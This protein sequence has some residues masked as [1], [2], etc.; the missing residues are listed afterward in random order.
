MSEQAS[1]VFL[2]SVCRSGAPV[3][4]CEHCGRV[5]FAP[6]FGDIDD[7]YLASLFKMEKETPDKCIQLEEGIACGMLNGRM[8]VYGC[9]CGTAIKY[10]RFIWDHRELICR[11]LVE[12]TSSILS[13]A[14][15][16]SALAKKMEN[17]LT[18][19]EVAQ[20]E[21]HRLRVILVLNGLSNEDD[22]PF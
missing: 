3:Q 22:V 14:E 12:R 1:D 16:E 17:G 18:D 13:E 10:E 21:I 2:N 5:Y 8:L 19:L 6:G 7:E 11:Y 4:E 15:N 9:R 20:S